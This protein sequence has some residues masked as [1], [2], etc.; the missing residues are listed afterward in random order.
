MAIVTL[1]RLERTLIKFISY[2]NKFKKNLRKV[3][4]NTKRG[5]KNIQLITSFKREIRYGF[6]L[7]KKACKGKVKISNPFAMVHS[8]SLNK[9]VI[10]VPT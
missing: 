10:I 1:T 4:E 6:T 8:R 2:I 7:A 3:K 5:L 9:L